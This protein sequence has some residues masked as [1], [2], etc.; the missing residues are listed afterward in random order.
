[1]PAKKAG[2]RS[3]KRYRRNGSVRT[4]TRTAISKA[5]RAVESGDVTV[6]EPTVKAAISVLD[7]A[8]RKRVLHKNNVARHKSRIS[9]KLNRIRGAGSA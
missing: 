9:A 4:V 8:V 1:M 7:R 3:L 6:A 5:L 2:R